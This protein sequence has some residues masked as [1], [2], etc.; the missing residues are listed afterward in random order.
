MGTC[1]RAIL[2]QCFASIIPTLAFVLPQTSPHNPNLLLSL[3]SSSEFPERYDAAALE[4]YFTENPGILV[5]RVTDLGGD[6]GSLAASLSLDALRAPRGG[7]SAADSYWRKVWLRRGPQL[8]RSL[9]RG[10]P[11]FVKFGQALASRSDLCGPAL[12]LEL[13]PLQDRL[14]PF[15][16]TLARAIVEAELL[17]GSGGATEERGGEVRALL[18]SM[19]AVPVAAAS[20]SQVYKASYLPTNVSNGGGGGGGSGEV[21][22]AVKVQRPGSRAL[23]GADAVLLRRAAAAV[24]AWTLPRS[25]LP[26]PSSSPPSLPPWVRVVEAELVGAVDE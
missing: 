19:S 20:V 16:S 17:L 10:G 1:A 7:G 18:A 8:R 6:V 3:S 22:V 23:V 26:W 12:A 21:A 5:K 24:E 13:L 9:E 14:E 11:T 2:L 4:R 15:N 25:L